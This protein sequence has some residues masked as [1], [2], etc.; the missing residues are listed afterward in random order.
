MKVTVIPIVVG[1]LGTI[2][3]GMV[4]GINKVHI[5]QKLDPRDSLMSEVQSISFMCLLSI[6]VPIRK[7]GLETY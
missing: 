1:A 5:F 6:K 3:K 7:K 2:P 4:K